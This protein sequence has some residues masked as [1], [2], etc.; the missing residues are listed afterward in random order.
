MDRNLFR[1]IEVAFPVEAPE[2]QTRIAEDLKLYLADD[3]QAWTLQPS[4][5]YT[6]VE[7]VQHVCAQTRL[8]SLYD[9]RVPLTDG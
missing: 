4:G 9:E 7:D 2:L 8:L 6:R 3:V 1:R 5:H